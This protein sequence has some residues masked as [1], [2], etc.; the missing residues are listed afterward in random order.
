L[1]QLLCAWIG[2]I[3]FL[4]SLAYFLFAYAVTFGETAAPASRLSPIL[5]DVLL[6]SVFALH[7]S[8]FARTGMK[9]AVARAW[10]PAAERA[11]YTWV[12][13][14]LFLVVCWAWRPV[15]GVLYEIPTP[16]HWVGYAVQLAG[17]VITVQA[18]RRLDVLDLAGVRATLQARTGEPP[19]HV[20]LETAGLYSLVRHPIYLGW[21]LFVF[22]A[23]RMTMT[24]FVFACVSTAYLAA[25]IPFE[26]RGLIDIFGDDYTGYQRRVRS[27]MLPFV[28]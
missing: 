4:A 27:R 7:H 19:R 22:G 9:T 28:Y 1:L 11:L 15:S 25:A 18:S 26:E 20:P 16:W 21:F 8:V 2:A 10:S 13:S 14:L 5:I 12:A 23:P 3:L 6:F 24:R 17:I